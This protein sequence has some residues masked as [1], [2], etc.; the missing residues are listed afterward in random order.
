MEEKA[1]LRAW[2]L[3]VLGCRVPGAQIDKCR[4]LSGETCVERADVGKLVHMLGV[5]WQVEMQS[6][7]DVSWVSKQVW[8]PGCVCGHICIEVMALYSTYEGIQSAGR[9]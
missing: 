4:V 8:V 1:G 7:G 5:K 6:N 3:N 2:G 9:W